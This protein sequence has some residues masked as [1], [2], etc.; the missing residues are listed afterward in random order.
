MAVSQDINLPLET[1]YPTKVARAICASH[2]RVVG[3]GFRVTMK[4]KMEI[5]DIIF[6]S[7]EIK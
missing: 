6:H 5:S 2:D 3:I 4:L 7:V 1:P